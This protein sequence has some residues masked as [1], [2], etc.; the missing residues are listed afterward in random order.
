[1]GSTGLGLLIEEHRGDVVATWRKTVERELGV[2]EPAMAFAV[3]PLLREMALA[4]TPR[5][6]DPH[7][8]PDA[9][10]D[11]W[12]RCAVMVR[13][14]TTAAQVAREFKLLHRC[15][16]ETF[17]A[18]DTLVS[19]GDRRA[20]DEW[21]DDAMAEALDRLERVRLR[22]A[23]FEQAPAQAQPPAAKPLP[24]AVIPGLKSRRQP[25]PLPVRSIPPPRAEDETI[26]E[27]D[28]IDAAV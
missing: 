5:Q 20:C 14:T 10:S 12:K 16:W 22:A 18:R 27:L 2:P 11:A 6:R 21:L 7:R 3:G 28:P 8:A 26:L 19:H 15:L 9:C 17:R 25:P 23:A 13:S 1:M 4:L 24:P